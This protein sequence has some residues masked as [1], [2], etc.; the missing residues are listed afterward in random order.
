M[1]YPNF[2]AYSISYSSNVAETILG[3]WAQNKA[4]ILID[5]SSNRSGEKTPGNI[6]IIFH[7]PKEDHIFYM[8]TWKYFNRIYF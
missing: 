1:K 4:R 6:L 3:D 8:E 2:A 5:P 7:T